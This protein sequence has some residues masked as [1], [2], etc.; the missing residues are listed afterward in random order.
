M[1]ALKC[2]FPYHYELQLKL[3]IYG[4]YMKYNNIYLKLQTTQMTKALQPYVGFNIVFNGRIF[5][6]S[7]IFTIDPNDSK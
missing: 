7:K 4:Q 6:K 3:N 2:S 5:L 1:D